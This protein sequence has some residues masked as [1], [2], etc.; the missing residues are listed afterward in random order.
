MSSISARLNFER[1][2]MAILQ[3]QRD[4]SLL[5]QQISSGQKAED[6]KGFGHNAGL[7][8]TTSGLLTQ[9]DS[10]LAAAKELDGRLTQQDWSMQRA[11]DAAKTLRT[12][13]LNAISANDG[14]TLVV[15]LETAFKEAT[16]ALNGQWQ[17]VYLFGGER[18]DTAPVAP[19][20]VEELLDETT[21]PTGADFFRESNR[22]AVIDLGDGVVIEAAP[23]AAELGATLFEGLRALKEVIGAGNRP[24]SS[25]LREDQIRALSSA[26]A[27]LNTAGDGLSLAQGRN[28]A[29]WKQIETETTRLENRLNLITNLKGERVD[30]NLAELAMRLSE[31]QVQY[32]AAA[33]TFSQLRD[34]S[35]LNYLR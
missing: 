4:L 25:P 1:P 14:S 29:T 8:V 2:Q 17:G 5:Q 30:A 35:L 15:A 33:Q 34:M 27:I 23:Q 22:K 26:A 31:M 3:M 9:T 21:Y 18:T 7:V 6:L 20:S 28:G 32:Q 24:P 12:D 16:V 10:R 19:Q 13:I 11:G